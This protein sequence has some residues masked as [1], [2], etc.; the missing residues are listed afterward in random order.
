M[1]KRGPRC[2]TND[3]ARQSLVAD[4]ATSVDRAFATGAV[5]SDV[6][7]ALYISAYYGS[8]PDGMIKQSENTRTYADG[9]TFHDKFISA[10]TVDGKRKGAKLFFDTDEKN[11]K[12]DCAKDPNQFVTDVNACME[13]AHGPAVSWI[14]NYS[15]YKDRNHQS[16]M[17]RYSLGN[18]VFGTKNAERVDTHQITPDL[19]TTNE[20][21]NLSQLATVSLRTPDGG[22]KQIEFLPPKGSKDLPLLHAVRVIDASGIQKIKV[23]DQVIPNQ[24]N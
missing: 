10:E 4:V 17:Q 22:Q 5:D 18:F 23:L 6:A 1:E 14:E 11:V 2:T 9:S 8:A 3:G 16:S 24:A 19:K 15:D 13:K 7:R 20:R 12:T 21:H